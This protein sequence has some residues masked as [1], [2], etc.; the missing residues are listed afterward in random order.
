MTFL[1]G[2]ELSW[3]RG[4]LATTFPDT[5]IIQAVTNASDGAGGVTPTWL[6][7]T[8]GTV[9]CRH[10]PLPR[11]G[12]QIEGG[13]EGIVLDSIFVLPYDAP[14][15]V[16]R[17]IVHNSLIYQTVVLATDQSWQLCQKVYVAY[18]SEENL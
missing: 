14:V 5:C 6:P 17:R 13:A 9:A 11:G 16:N 7:V 4:D 3:M 15:A 2:D 12:P 8:G 10:D 1:S 18:L